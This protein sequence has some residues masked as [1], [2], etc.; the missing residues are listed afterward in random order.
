MTA[1]VQFVFTPSGSRDLGLAIAASRAGE[2][3]VY[4]AEFEPD[5]AIVIASLDSMVRHARGGFGLRLGVVD[6]GVGAALESAARRGL[7]WLIADGRQ[8]TTQATLIAA[9]RHQGVKVLV[10]VITPEPLAAAVA[11]GVDGILVKGNESGGYVGEDASFILLQKWLKQA[12]PGLPLYLRGGLTPHVA[13]ACQAVGVAGGVFE[14]QLLLLDEIRLPAALRNII[15][16]LSGSETVAAGDGERGQYFRLLI[17]PSMTA[18][19]AFVAEADGRDHEQLA[20]GLGLRF[21]IVQGPM[22]RVSDTAEFALAVA[23]GGALP[24]VAFAL[25]KGQALE[26][27]LNA[28]PR[29][30]ARAALGHR[31]ARLRAA[32][33]ARRTTGDRE[34]SSSRPTRSSP[35]VGPTRPCTWSVPASRRSCT[36][37][38]RQPD[39]GL[40]AGGR[41]ALHLR[42][43]RVRRPHRAAVE[44]R[45]LEH[46]GRQ[47]ARRVRRRQ[48][49]AGGGAAA[50]RRRHPRRRVVG[51][52]AG[53][54][55]AAGGAGAQVGILMG[56]AY[57]FTREIV[58]S[59]SIVPQFQQEVLECA[60]TVSLESGPGHASRCAY[61]PF[62]KDFFRQRRRDC[63]TA[64]RARRR[65]SPRARRPDPRPPAHRLQGQQAR[66]PERCRCRRLET[67]QQHAEGMYMLGQVVTL[68]DAASPRR[69]PA[70]EVTEG[71]AAL[72]VAQHLDLPETLSRAAGPAPADIAIVGM[73]TCC[74]RPQS[75]EYWENILAKVDAITE[76]PRHRWD[77]RLYFDADRQAK[78]KIYS[79]WG[80]FLDDL[81]FD[82]T[83]YG[84]PPKS[85][86]SVDPM[87]L[88]GL[89]VAHRTLV[90]SGYHQKRLRPRAASVILGASGGAGDYGLMY[91]LRSELPRFA[92]ALPPDVAGAP[93]RVDRRLV[94]R[95]PAQRRVRAHRQPAEFRRHQR[96]GR[97]GLRVVAGGRLPGRLRTGRRAQRLRHRRWRRHRA[98]PV[99]LPLLQQDPGPVA[100]RPLLT[101]SMP[102]ATA[103]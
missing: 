88:M 22:T 19:R 86:E 40:P 34:R 27:L 39:P 35:A 14:S 101:P 6:A 97:C 49:A 53:A 96:C 74:R 91:G 12:P 8:L 29:C 66:W 41:A 90:D 82:P 45:A 60:H 44:L 30:W 61:T 47:A 51:D 36:C 56:S 15:A 4:N 85:I 102:P 72:L 71:A 103:S 59:G 33:P 25:L 1:F 92:G 23:E 42:R 7:A 70:H 43:P 75:R 69:G 54:G 10:E 79:K 68:R 83:Q 87:Q 48:G 17:R 46:D 78:D 95:H 26:T 100:A 77:W 98:G 67:A 65:E 64:G 20:A 99:R 5:G 94:R 50:V 16:N 58:D 37:R 21:P 89:E 2:I 28:P 11:A 32:E 76:I 57:L 62:A 84:M 31:P 52:A 73:A 38:H 13:A 80:G 18:A 63:A 24:M 81:A 55:R 9:L 3:G 93:A